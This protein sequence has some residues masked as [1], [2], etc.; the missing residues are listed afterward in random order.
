[1]IE[2]GNAFIWKHTSCDKL[3][4]KKKKQ[5]R[6]EIKSNSVFCS[7]EGK[8][9]RERE[10]RVFGTFP[11]Q[12]AHLCNGP[13]PLPSRKKILTIETFGPDNY[14]GSILSAACE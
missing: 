14:S 5:Q 7:K 13:P 1:M 2:S 10:K 8:N 6:E 12:M 4:Q 11:R 3:E 9:V